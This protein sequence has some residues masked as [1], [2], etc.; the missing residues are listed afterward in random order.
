MIS[1]PWGKGRW[2]H[3]RVLRTVGIVTL[4]IVIIMALVGAYAFDFTASPRSFFIYWSIF[5][6]LLLGVIGVAVIDAIATIIRFRKE[7]MKLR[8]MFRREL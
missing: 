1:D 4:V 6:T 5:F 2:T 7:H 3:R 8:N